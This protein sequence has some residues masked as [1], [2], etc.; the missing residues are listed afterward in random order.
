MMD[1]RIIIKVAVI[2]LLTAGICHAAGC[3]KNRPSCQPEK[4][5]P[6]PPACR[7]EK[8]NPDPIETILRRLNCR[9]SNLNRYQ[10][11][12]EYLVTQPLFES[13][14]LRT[15][16]LYYQRT[17]KKSALRINFQTLKQDDEKQQ[18]HIEHFI[19]DGQWLTIIDYQIKTVKMHQLAEPNDPVDAF[20]LASRNFPII[21]FV[22]TEDLRE[23]FEIKLVEQKDDNSLDFIQ[24]H[25][26]VKPTSV[27]K[28][29]YRT[30]DFWIDRASALPARIAA[31]STEGEIYQIKLLEP[32]VNKG[33]DKKVFEIR[34]PEGFT[35]EERR[36]EKIEKK[37]D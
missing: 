18:K 10:C 20:E 16:V 36:L 9:I 4:T 12:M 27:Y 37:K 34:I 29:D 1:K 25:L 2:I 15:G 31:V 11:R 5:N 6:D 32:E 13:K 19:F 23:Q 7:G 14:T 30:V 3:V 17:G 21:G 22:R 35:V 8:T 26:K 24:L 28:D 33:I